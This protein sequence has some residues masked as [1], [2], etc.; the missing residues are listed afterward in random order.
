MKNYL[1]KH[2][3]S[4]LL[5]VLVAIG[6]YSMAQA[7]LVNVN[8]QVQLDDDQNKLEVTTRGQCNNNNH[9]GCIHVKQ[10]KQ[11]SKNQFFVWGKPAMQQARGCELGNW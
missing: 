1:A 7:Q 3:L 6:F 2:R 11:A 4:Q 9:K 8:V 5:V 10:G